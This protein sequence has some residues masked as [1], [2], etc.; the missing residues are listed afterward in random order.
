MKTSIEISDFLKEPSFQPSLMDQTLLSTAQLE[1]FLHTQKTSQ[2]YSQ[3]H[4]CPFH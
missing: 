3:S 4:V 2:A 1:I